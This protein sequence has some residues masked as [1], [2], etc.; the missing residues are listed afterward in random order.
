MFR[1]YVMLGAIN[2][3]V[4]V[5]LGAFG[6]HGLQGMITEHYLEIYETGVRYHMIHALGL[7]AVALIADRIGENNLIKWSGR[8][9]FTGILF[10]SLSLYVLALTSIGILG[11]ITPIGGV[12]FLTGWALMAASVYKSKR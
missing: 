2:L 9:L 7:L 12:C 4:S 5:A 3:L 8:L 1:T 6:A 10:F 11:A